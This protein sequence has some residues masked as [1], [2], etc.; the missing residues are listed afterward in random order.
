MSSLK[1][2]MERL[3]QKHREQ[4][5][6]NDSGLN[7]LSGIMKHNNS[8]SYVSSRQNDGITAHSYINFQTDVSALF[9]WFFMNNNGISY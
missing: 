2:Q 5:N 9:F 1:K 4:T 7:M 6:Q 8:S 3:K